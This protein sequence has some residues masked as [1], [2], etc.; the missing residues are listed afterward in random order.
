MKIIIKVSLLFFMVTNL[1]GT[2]PGFLTEIADSP[3]TAGS[4]PRSVAY[5]PDGLFLA[6]ANE[7]SG[8]ISVFAVNQITGALTVVPGSPF[9]A[10]NGPRSVAYSPDGLFLAVANQ[11]SNNVSVFGV[12]QLPTDALSRAIYLKY[13]GF[14]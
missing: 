4:E 2:V 10:G 12:E 14:C 9:A 7:I 11:D 8:D 1:I 3:F 5:S 6:V 13:V